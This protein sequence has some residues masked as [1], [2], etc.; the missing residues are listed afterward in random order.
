MNK[1]S[2]DWTNS[3]GDFFIVYSSDNTNSKTITLP[4]C[5]SYLSFYNLEILIFKGVLNCNKIAPSCNPQS[6][7]S[8]SCS[9]KKSKILFSKEDLFTELFN[10]DLQKS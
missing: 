2:Y 4:S 1:I 5:N 3:F 9:N 6:P 10:S 7:D 8:K